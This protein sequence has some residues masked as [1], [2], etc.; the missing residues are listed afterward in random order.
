MDPLGQAIFD[1]GAV[2]VKCD[3][4]RLFKRVERFNCRHELHTIIGRVRV[5]A[6]QLFAIITRDKQYA[7][8][9]RSWIAA[10][11]AVGPNL[12]V[13]FCHGLSGGSIS[14]SRQARGAAVCANEIYVEF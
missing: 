12:N 14:K 1:V 4:A 5:T 7:P 9:A 3:L 6:M 11:R 10:T 13:W 8:A 2:G